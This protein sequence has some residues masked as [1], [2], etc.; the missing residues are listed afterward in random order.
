MAEYNYIDHSDIN[1]VSGLIESPNYPKFFSSALRKTYRITVQQGSVIRIEFPVFYMDE[2]D[3]DECF[4]FI[5]IYNGYDDAAPLLQDETCSDSPAPI[6]SESNAVF[7]EFMNN[8]MSKTKFRIKWS[9]VDRVINN[10]G[11]I[12]NNCSDVVLSLNTEKDMINITSPGYPYGYDT[13]LSCKWTITSKL[14]AFHP[15]I[16]FKDID[17]EDLSGCYGDYVQVSTDRD[18]GTWKEH[19]KLCA[20]DLR[21]RK[22]FEGTPNLKLAFV[23]DYGTNRTGFSAY[24]QLECGGKMTESEGI[25][26]YNTTNLFSLYRVMNDCKW[27]ITVRRGK[28]IQ[29]E[30]LELNIQNTSHI[31]NSY[32][33]IRNGIDD[34]SPYVGSGQYC[35]KDIP[36]IPPTSSNRA[37]VKYKVN[38]PLLN[39]FKLRYSEVQHSCGGQI[40]LS[41]NNNS[42]IVSSPHYPNIPPPHI[43]CTWTILVPTGERIRVDFIE[44]FDLTFSTDCSKEY[45]ELRDGLTTSSHQIGT[46][47]GEKPVTKTSK[48]NVMMMKF[49]TDVAE[50]KNGFKAN[51][52]IDVCGGTI[53][54]NAGYLTSPKYP[55]L[56]AYPSKA[57]CDYRIS[58]QINHIFNITIVSIDLPPVNGTTDECDETSDHFKIF[59][60]IP[61]FNGTDEEGNLRE[62]GLFCGS[63]IPSIS[64]FS[65]T[66]EFLVR[67]ITMEKTKNLYKGFKILYQASKTSCGGLIE[68]PSGIITSPGYPTHTLNKLFCEWKITVPKGRRVKIEFLDVDLLASSSQ[69]LQRIGV[70]NDFR[71]SNRLMFLNSNSSL[72]EPLYSS[73]NRMMVTMWVRLPSS[74]RG[75]KL[76]FSSDD[77]TV[78]DGNLNDQTGGIFPPLDLNLTSYTCDYIRDPTPIVTENRGTLAYYFKNISVGKKITNCRYAS[79]VINVKRRSGVGVFDDETFLAQICGNT[80]TSLTVLSPFPDVNIEVR[81][82]PFFGQINYTMHYKTFNC[83]GMFSNGEMT[84]IRN[85]PANISNEAILDCAWFVKYQEGF[86]VSISFSQLKMKLP[87]EQEYIQVYNGPTALSPSIGK[88]CGTDASRDVMVSQK[89]TIFIEYHTDN[90]VGSSKDSVFEIKLESASFGCGGILNKNN[91]RF[92]TP[93]YMKGYPPNTECIWE[94]RAE[95]GYHVGLTFEDRF[96]I[97]TTTNC[98]KDYLEVFDFVNDDW[99]SLGRRCGRNVPEP[100]NSTAEKMKVIFRSDSSST[101]EG[102]KALWTQNCGGIFEVDETPRLLSS[103]GFPKLYGSNLICNYTLVAKDSKSFINLNFLEFAV[104]TTGSKCMYDNITIWK[105]SDYSYTVENPPEKVGTFCGTTNPG[106][107]RHRAKTTI[108][109]QSDRWVERK[110]FQVEYKLDNCGGT[111][112]N[113]S[114]ISSPTFP[115]S[116]SYYGVMHCAWNI[117]APDNKKIIIKFENFSMEH[118]DYCSNDYIEIFNGTKVNDSMRLAKI[119]GNLTNV[120]KPIIINNNQAIIRLSTYQTTSYLGFSAIV[121]FK[122]KCDQN[123]VLDNDRKTIVIDKMNQVYSESMECV[124][125]ISGVPMSALKLTFDEM[126]LSICDPDKNS[127]PCDCDYVE[128]LDGNGPFSE[129]IGRFCGH[130]SSRGIVS[131]SSSLYIRFV[132]DSLRPSTGFKA[133]ITMIESPC[134]SVPYMNF[135]ANNTSEYYVLSPLIPGSPNYVPNIRCT[136]IAE[137]S[138]YG[139]IFEI[140]FSKFEL[141]DSPFCVNDSLTIQDYSMSSTIT[142]GLGEEVI[143]RGKSSA[144]HSPSFYSGIVGPTAPHVYCGSGLPPDF[145]SQTNKIK[146]SFRSNEQNEF[147]GFNFTI[148]TMKSCSRNFT[149]LQGRLVSD[150]ALENCRSFIKV[151]ENYTISLYFNKFFSYEN[152]CTKTFL[153]IYDGDFENGVL[154]KTLCGY[155]TPD[156]IF[157][158]RNQI[159]LVFQFEE[160][161]QH[162]MRGNYDFLYVATDKG[163][164]CGGEIFN[165]GGLITSPLYPSSNRTVNNCYWSLTVPQNLKVA[166]RFTSKRFKFMPRFHHLIVLLTFHIHSIRHGFKIVV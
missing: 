100:F 67:M 98:S 2:E 47:C 107:F 5:K 54:S 132:T 93:L 150:D 153:K 60:I 68:A 1:G 53:R 112:T 102:F 97:E 34:S 21:E 45:V 41:A 44:R 57:R 49:F 10:T 104:E 114:M 164:G 120:L 103:P 96:N 125:K 39:S 83:G 147:S 55:G 16:V 50:P 76:K 70:Y 161:S 37:F 62:V 110:G 14:P 52:S 4:A 7:I 166:L 159:S 109:F 84:F 31:C 122:P 35:G 99:T 133:R 30:F 33:T 126:H 27:N 94:I 149:A 160:G 6:T 87:C 148:R 24:T 136:W 3:A 80:T 130:N 38:V 15:I 12:Q 32:V 36:K 142:E 48:S 92:M 162:Y 113:S 89:N 66:N 75:F 23:S 144:T 51:I 22:V 117:T 121:S 40:R 42:I 77:S 106:K 58:G 146:I 158:T 78:C 95:S 156:P 56:G 105:N 28:T 157:S 128:V 29:F 88:F 63:E 19:E 73:D 90:F 8:H 71:Y 46:F 135:T 119:C 64:Y 43:D 108:V 139:K 11:T 13:A 140:Q 85:S 151:P 91:H 155:A 18:D 152:D 163:Q 74:N 141:E 59:S 61:D 118:S 17:L 131:S 116:N 69:L 127:D 145:L 26:E 165:Y 20:S 129:V 115:D 86:S 79:T 9:E 143:Y 82:N 72:I 138:A 154:M 124:Y 111:V 134:G 123:F 81:Q 65:D 101:A 25:I 137:A